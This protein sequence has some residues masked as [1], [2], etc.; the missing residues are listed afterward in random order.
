M[1]KITIRTDDAAGFFNS[2]REAARKADSGGVFE[3]GKV[4]LSFE[5]PKDMLSVLSEG[6]RKLML[7][8]MRQPRTISELVGSLQR[9]RSSISKDVSLLEGLGLLLSERI[10]N[11]AG[12]G[13]QR[14][15]Q[16]VAPKIEMVSTLG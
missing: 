10:A 6:R 16:A 9:P 15:V 8:V 3:A 11:K 2:A 12:H 5:D 4:T 13:V 1:Q 14:L 7:E